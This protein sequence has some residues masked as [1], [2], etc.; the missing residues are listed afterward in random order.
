MAKPHIPDLEAIKELQG[1]DIRFYAIIGAI[2]SVAAAIEGRF[3][4]FFRL[5]TR[6]SRKRAAS[7]FYVIRTAGTR[8]IMADK[9]MRT[10][11]SADGLKEWSVLIER[12]GQAT[13]DNGLRNFLGHSPLSSDLVPGPFD[14]AIFDPAIF[15][16]EREE[17]FIEQDNN[18][19]LSG[20][21]KYRR[22]DFDSALE[23]CRE[24]IAL[25]RALDAFMGGYELG[26]YRRN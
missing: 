23:H 2:M 20:D 21:K 6:L 19:V 1:A 15:D 18:H 24:L 10:V 8:R 11:L 4:D 26:D 16:T 14:P 5:A 7:I 13:G 22:E 25:L 17:Y 9:V 12:V 3:F